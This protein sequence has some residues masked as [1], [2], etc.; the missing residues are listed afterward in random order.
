MAV[1][2]YCQGQSRRFKGPN[3]HLVE[4]EKHSK[5]SL[6]NEYALHIKETKPPGG[7]CGGD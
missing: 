4:Q 5:D 2:E 6:S 1:D 3:N 7:G